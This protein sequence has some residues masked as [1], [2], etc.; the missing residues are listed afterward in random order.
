VKIET[1]WTEREGANVIYA[2]QQRY[3]NLGAR[4]LLKYAVRETVEMG[5]IRRQIERNAQKRR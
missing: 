1:I 2:L 4:T 5:R 3:G